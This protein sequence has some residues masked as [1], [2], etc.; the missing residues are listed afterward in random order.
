MSYASRVSGVI[1][2]RMR[3][4]LRLLSRGALWP[5]VVLRKPEEECCVL[6]V[7][8]LLFLRLVGLFVACDPRCKSERVGSSRSDV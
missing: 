3:Q 7:V 5:K 6:P 8:Q 1:E 4:L 2:R